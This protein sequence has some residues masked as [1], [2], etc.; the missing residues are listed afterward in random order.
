MVVGKPV[1]RMTAFQVPEGVLM[2][3]VMAFETRVGNRHCTETV[4]EAA[5]QFSPG[6]HQI[7]KLLIYIEKMVGRDRLELSTKGL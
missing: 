7:N 1:L 6:K 4:T 5:V 3:A 2:I